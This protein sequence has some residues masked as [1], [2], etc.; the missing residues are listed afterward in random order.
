MQVQ[1]VNGNVPF[2]PVGSDTLKRY[3]NIV[4]TILKQYTVLRNREILG[5]SR[6]VVNSLL[7][8]I[9]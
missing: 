1:L 8:G 7:P 6:G 2:S 3:E 5:D 4:R 9:A